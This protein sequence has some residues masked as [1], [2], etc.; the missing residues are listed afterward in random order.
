MSSEADAQVS[1]DGRWVAYVSAE[2]GQNEVYVHPF[3]GPGGKERVSTQGGDSVR[4]SHSG[5]ELFYMIRNG[6]GVLMTVDFQTAPRLHIGL[7]QVLTKTTF[8]TTWDPAPDGK[9]LLVEI[10]SGSTEGA[11]VMYG[12]GD[13][14]DE[15]SRRV[16]VKR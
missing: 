13:W 1:P 12:I 11:R 5:R 14:F 6:Q 16:P 15:L 7:P 2:T 4:W 3:P 8:G 9:H 10:T